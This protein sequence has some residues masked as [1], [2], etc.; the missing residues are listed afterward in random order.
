[1]SGQSKI[2]RTAVAVVAAMLMSTVTIGTAVGP[3]HA[4]ANP[5]ESMLHA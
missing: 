4:I 1:M 5:A 3:A 2:M